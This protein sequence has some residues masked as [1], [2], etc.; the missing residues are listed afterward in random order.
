MEDVQQQTDLQPRFN[1]L[2]VED[3][4][5]DQ[6][7]VEAM[8]EQAF[9]VN[10]ELHC[11]THFSD[12]AHSLE[13]NKHFNMLILDMN[14]PDR[15]GVGN[16]TELS[17][18]YPNLPIIVLTGDRNS[19]TAL[20]TLKNG[21]QDFLNKNDVTPEALSRS[22]RYAQQR[23]N[24]E[25]QLTFALGELERRNK[26]LELLA[27]RDALTGLPNR[28]F[29]QELATIRLHEAEVSDSVVGLLFID[30]NGFKKVNDTYGHNA[31]DQLLMVVADRLKSQV[32]END[33]AARLGGDEFV[34]LTEQLDSRKS[35]Q[36]I[37]K[38]LM[39]AFSSPCQLDEHSVHITPSVG[40]AFFPDAH[41]L[42]ELLQQAD[43]AMYQAKAST[44]SSIYIYNK[45]LESKFERNSQIGNQLKNALRK[46]ELSV[47]FQP[48]SAVASPHTIYM[49]SLIRWNSPELGIVRPDEFIDVAE[50]TPVINDITQ[51]VIRYSANTVKQ[52]KD[53][54]L[55]HL[56]EKIAIN[57]CAS[58][59]DDENFYARFISWAQS[60]NMP[61]DKVCIEITERQL[62]EK[63]QLCKLHFSKLKKMGVS[64]ALDDFGTGYSSLTHLVELDIDILKIDRKLISNIDTNP[65]NAALVS[66]ITE[67]AH[68]LGLIVI[69]EGIERLEE[70]KLLAGINCDFLQGFFIEKPLTH[71]AVID[72]YQSYCTPH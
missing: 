4:P 58:Q 30:L 52:L 40:V 36:P 18:R 65:D 69:A 31:G 53:N 1:I 8:L 47:S 13:T 12:I 50:K 24:I 43:M 38:R 48:V 37:I 6:A 2:L 32:R 3:S 23:K 39:N 54:N 27:Q 17:D 19:E 61:L 11:V 35:I 16:V 5:L 57:I 25:Q 14:L 72:F 29:F 21:A 63:T 66:G 64:I 59:L 10:Y 44:K 49:E 28:G 45:A 9:S 42:E 34:I 7:L 71:D 70:Y 67:M 33:F 56:L 22:L 68:R 41:S 60:A 55:D 51:Q 20:Q 26:E 62:I 46:D 15:S